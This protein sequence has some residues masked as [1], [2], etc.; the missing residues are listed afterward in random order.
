M[1]VLYRQ[2]RKP[3]RKHRLTRV[4]E[5]LG[6]DV[7]QVPD[8]ALEASPADIVWIWGNANWYPRAV[9]ELA[10]R[11]PERRPAVVVWHSEPLPYSKRAGLRQARLHLREIAKIVL[12]DSRATDPYTNA[13][14][15]RQ[16]AEHGLPDVLAVTSEAQREFLRE[17][18]IACE[19]AP[20]GYHPSQ[21]SDLG[22]ERD[23]DVLFLGALEVPRRKRAFR[24]LRRSGV[25]V[26]AAGDW[27]DPRYWG[28]K[29]TR[30]LNR[31][32]ILLNI[33]RH[34]GQYSGERL[35]LGMA[36]GALVIS[37]PIYRPEPFVP[38]EHFV[39]ASLDETAAVVRHYLGNDHERRQLAKSGHAFVTGELSMTQ[40]VSRILDVLA[41]RLHARD[42]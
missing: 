2:L 38:G 22:L 28:A 15:L 31:A 30:L 23:V 33:S 40:S 14:R 41:R 10:A 35:V 8:G 25:D 34:P 5:E 42:G 7:T 27:G 12:R 37:E 18:G 3:A 21:G 32:K 11:P 13:R 26:L 20:I 19:V 9:R 6:H 1:T 29:R 36:N 17:V 39:A 16:L 24:A 4:L